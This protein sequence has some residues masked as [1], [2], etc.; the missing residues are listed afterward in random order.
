MD[1]YQIKALSFTYP[2]ASRRALFLPELCLGK[3]EFTVLCGRSGCGKTTL[4][5]HLKPALTPHGESAGEILF[6]GK[7]LAELGLREQASRIGFVQQNPDNQIVTD[8]VWHEL[9]FGLESLGTDSETLRLRV[10]ETAGFFGIQ[11][12]FRESVSR[13]SG[14][15]KQL[16]SL[17]SVMAM[18]PEVLILD[19][20][21]GQL[22][23]VAAGEFLDMV[24]RINRELGITVLL[25][26]QRL[27]AVF[28]MADRVL[29][30]DEG[31]IIADGSPR[32]A[33]TRLEAM[34][35]PMRYALPSPMQIYAG[36]KN[37]LPC[38]VTVREGRQ[39]LDRLEIRP[40]V[41][42]SAGREKPDTLQKPDPPAIE[43]REVWFRYEKPLPDVLRGLTMK[44]PGG[45]L[46]CI[47]GGN[48][49]GKTTALS[50]MAGLLR[51]YRGQVCLG[52]EV[53]SGKAAGHGGMRLSMLP[54]S[55]QTLFVKSTV[56][57]DLLEMLEG[58]AISPGEREDRLRAVSELTEIAGLLSR[59]PFDLS[60][61]E[62]QRAALAKVLLAEPQILLMDEPTKGMDGDF[63][64]RLASILKELT[65]RGVTV[66][67]VSHDI[68]FCARYAD[69]CCLFFDGGMV[70]EGAPG[71]F[72][73]GNSVYTTAAN[74][75]ARHVFPEAVT[76][77]DVIKRAN[78][79]L[80]SR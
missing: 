55:P 35:H 41:P 50:V 34:E 26:E 51:P 36:I 8:K 17:A 79:A 23:P 57:A 29:V 47:A 33:G 52:G 68:E 58:G 21:T 22:D 2:L 12:W 75:M 9:A 7:P 37:N 61:G 27:E 80:G 16:L 46:Y 38:P 19:E 4:L 48:G 77:E 45:V 10:A 6:F 1:V 43:L 49:S 42:A 54:Q 59:H 62:Q 44:I 39:W 74:R 5:R 64:L 71:S 11:G 30:M 32:E 25:S 14:G 53:L 15:Q 31:E 3:G 20:P 70:S 65:G 67:M 63:K 72:F 66:V 69:L 40:Q 56:R 73:S 60:G 28:P 78:A 13:L 24:Q 18:Q 76:A